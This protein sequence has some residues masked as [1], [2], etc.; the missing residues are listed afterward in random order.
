MSAALPSNLSGLDLRCS[1]APC[2][3]FGPNVVDQGHAFGIGQTMHIGDVDHTAIAAGLHYSPAVSLPPQPAKPMPLLLPRQGSHDA[4]V[5][6]Y[7]I[8]TLAG[9]IITSVMTDC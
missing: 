1:G 2:S 4:L 3:T 9:E 6:R 5:V 8:S 7:H